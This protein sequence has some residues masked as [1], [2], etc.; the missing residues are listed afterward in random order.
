M[1]VDRISV[2]LVTKAHIKAYLINNFGEKPLIDCKHIF[3]NYLLLCY[4]HS[5]TYKMD[6]L[7][8]N[9]VEMNIYITPDDYN[10][11]GCW[12]NARQ[13]HFFNCHAEDY[14]KS[15]VIAMADTYLEVHPQ[16]KLKNALEYALRQIKLTDEDW[17]METVTKFYYRHRKYTGKPLLYNKPNN[18][19][20]KMS[21]TK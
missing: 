12:L 9:S 8:R 2:K 4:S 5:L 15:L 6:D 14:M 19:L 7:N 11:Y 13:M 18:F 10:R 21:D 3:H 16:P 1:P 20:G 17:D